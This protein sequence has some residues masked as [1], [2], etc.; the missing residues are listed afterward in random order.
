ML[1]F[2]LRPSICFF[3]LAI[4][5]STLHLG[6]AYAQGPPA[7]LVPDLNAD[8]GDDP[9]HELRYRNATF[10]RYNALGLTN[11]SWAGYR[12]NLYGDSTSILFKDCYIDLGLAPEFTP[13]IA[14]IG[15]KIFIKPLAL[16]EMTAVYEW[17]QFFGTFD[18]I[19]FFESATENFSEDRIKE[20]GNQGLTRVSNFGQLTLTGRLQGK[21]GPIAFRSRL[22]ALRID[23]VD[24]KPGQRTFYDPTWDNIAA[25]KSWTLAT[26]TDLLYLRG[27]LTVG[28][29]HT[30]QDALYQSRHIAPGESLDDINSKQQRI[31]PLIA[32]KIS[33]NPNS[34][35]ESATLFALVQ[36]WVDHPYRTG[37]ESSQAIPQIAIGYAFSGSLMSW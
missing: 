22:T 34:A 18:H 30:W 29:R 24:L 13:A 11:Q 15:P 26:D 23:H 35:F 9:T 4:L 3:A 31:G 32:Y 5:I 10:A 2:R 14:R 36:W 28:L 21:V 1:P 17:V 6:Q 33:D 25:P 8:P 7:T 20:L 27:P 12:Y 19:Q 37:Q 16:L